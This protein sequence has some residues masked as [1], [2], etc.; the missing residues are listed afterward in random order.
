MI[1]RRAEGIPLA[2]FAPGIDIEQFGGHIPGT[3][4]GAFSGALPLVRAKTMQGGF[5]AAGAGITADQVQ[6]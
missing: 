4:R 5:F 3:L 2:C 6:G 1:I